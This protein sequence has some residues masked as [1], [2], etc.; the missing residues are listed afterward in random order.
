MPLRT[1]RELLAS[2]AAS[3]IPPARPAP[4][5]PS[6]SAA[7]PGIAVWQFTDA[8]VLA[9]YVGLTAILVGIIEMPMLCSCRSESAR[10]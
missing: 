3:L 5:L 10:G 1:V 2:G 4:S 8:T 6:P 7:M 9:L